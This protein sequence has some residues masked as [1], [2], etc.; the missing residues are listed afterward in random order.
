MVR[1]TSELRWELFAHEGLAVVPVLG[2]DTVGCEGDA[3]TGG[4]LE[5]ERLLLQVGGHMPV[6]SPVPPHGQP[7]RP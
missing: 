4:H 7:P 3:V 1:R 5:G 6:L 2:G